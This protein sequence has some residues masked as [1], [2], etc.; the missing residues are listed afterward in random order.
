MYL[1]HKNLKNNL[2][3]R[4]GSLFSFVRVRFSF[5]V[6]GGLLSLGI[7]ACYSAE[8]SSEF[9]N[10]PNAPYVRSI[11]RTPFETDF[12]K[13]TLAFLQERSFANNREYCGYI[14][15][16]A[17]R[18]P[19]LA[20]QYIASPAKRG[21]KGSCMTQAVPR[22]FQVLASYHTHGAYSEDF[23]S[24]LPSSDD[25][26]SDIEEGIDGYIATPGGRLW[27]SNSQLGRVE[28]ICSEACLP[29]DPNYQGSYDP[30]FNV[31][32]LSRIYTLEQ[33]QA[34]ENL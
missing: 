15:V 33:L 19:N 18:D 9:L 14:G 7:T 2:V 34:F 27:F 28:L 10:V 21:R 29:Q 25:L 32:R 6:G 26:L 17:K 3:H 23:D 12:A 5:A 8:L 22:D 30:M 11:E 16:D 31:N 1:N 13:K 20:V 4:V 24:E